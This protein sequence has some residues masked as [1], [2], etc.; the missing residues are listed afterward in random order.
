MFEELRDRNLLVEKFYLSDIIYNRL[1]RKRGINYQNIEKHLNGLDFKIILI[2]MPEDKKLIQDRINDRLK[3]YPHY[4]SILHQ[5]EWY[6]E[7]QNQYLKEVKKT[8][9]PYLVVETKKL[10]DKTLTK[11]ILSWINEK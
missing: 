6:I 2:T 1:Y 7:Q 9:L 5:P 8:G 10:P 4:R 11:K 3:L